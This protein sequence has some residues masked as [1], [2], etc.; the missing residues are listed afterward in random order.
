MR[1]QARFHRRSNPQGLMNPRKVVVHV[2]QG[3]HR[4]VVLDLLTE[5]IRQPG[6]AAHVHSHVEV[7]SLNVAGRNVCLI[8]RSN[9][10][11]A[12]GALTLRRAVALL[13]LQ[14]RCRTPSQVAR[15]RCP[16]RTHPARRPGTSYGR[17]W[18]TGCD[19]TNALQCPEETTFTAFEAQ[20]NLLSVGWLAGGMPGVRQ[21]QRVHTFSIHHRFSMSI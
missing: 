2:K 5:G 19:S 10:L 12:L 13:C 7:L 3:D 6:E 11:D 1:T 18:S 16:I 4:N 15:S 14:D 21:A 9:N 17:P 8:G 20:T